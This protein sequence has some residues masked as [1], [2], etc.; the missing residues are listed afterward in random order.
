MPTVGNA[1]RWR[2]GRAHRPAAAGGRQEGIW[3]M[4]E[5]NAQSLHLPEGAGCTVAPPEAATAGEPLA[6]AK[7]VGDAPAM[8]AADLDAMLAAGAAPEDGRPAH[9]AGGHGATATVPSDVA[10][11]AVDGEAGGA[12]PATET[13]PVLVIA[14]PLDRTPLVHRVEP[15]EA[16]ELRGKGFAHAGLLFVDGGLL[17]LLSD[18]R[19]VFLADY[20]AAADEGLPPYLTLE[21]APLV[22]NADLAA[23]LAEVVPPVEPG[24]G[25]EAPT[26]PESDGGGAGFSPY[27][28]GTIGDG[29]GP[30]GPL[31]PT[32][33]AYDAP[34]L[35]PL[36]PGA[37][38]AHPTPL[39]P[40]DDAHE[41][42]GPIDGGSG[43][44][45]EP[46]LPGTGTNP[47]Y[48]PLNH[49][50]PNHLPLSEPDKIVVVPDHI[51]P[52][53]LNAHAGTD[54]DGDT[55]VYRLDDLPDPAFGTVQL[56]H[57][58][59]A[60]APGRILSEAEYLTLRFDPAEGAA[61][62][63]FTLRYTVLDGKGGEDEGL[64]RIEVRDAADGDW[65][66]AGG[67]G[68]DVLQ[69]GYGDDVL[70]GGA[71]DDFLKGGAGADTLYGGYGDDVLHGGGGDDLLIG[72][73]GADRLTPGE[74]G[75]VIVDDLAGRNDPDG[76]FLVNGGP[77]YDRL[78]V[79]G[80][81]L[82]LD[83]TDLAD[84]RLQ[85]VEEID[86]GG[87]GN[88]IVLDISEVLNLAQTNGSLHVAGGAGDAV[89][90]HLHGAVVGH[91][92]AD[93]TVYGLGEMRLVVDNAVDQS[94]LVT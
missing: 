26:A 92:D 12:T 22:V 4:A 29:L 87:R 35:R 85:N 47:N 59:P 15:G 1:T 6:Q 11:S 3:G 21:G 65:H 14:E 42:G 74:G 62:R 70:D 60:L 2:T 56:G 5:T 40:G 86:L 23:A 81:G 27:D 93:F 10:G 8:T 79:D 43:G 20:A 36:A 57:D 51:G 82:T 68:H 64:M 13:I 90:G 31:G 9:A 77:G 91:E 33:L 46:S 52:Q 16:I 63:C 89:A 49:L 44:K 76:P 30:L 18:G 25:P 80:D 84:H 24:A 32:A 37:A 28:A 19:S 50:P 55:L 69:G 72:G 48:P 7:R 61:G 75:D 71:G 73:A 58:G 88:R 67:T 54:P 83:L 94:G 78:V 17:V 34:A 38:A 41:P 53:T 39:G 66:V 45:G